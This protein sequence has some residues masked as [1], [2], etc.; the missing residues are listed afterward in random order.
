MKVI[1][2]ENLTKVFRSGFLGKPITVLK[3]IS[4]TVEK[5]EIFG[6]IGPNGAGKTTTIKIIM[7][8]LRPTSG[9]V[10]IF[11]KP[12]SDIS[13]RSKVGFLPEN[14]YF[15]DYLKARE[16]LYFY[17]KLLSMNKDYLIERIDFLLDLVGLKGIENVFLRNYS[18]GMLQRIGIAQAL[19]AD[20][21]LLILDEPMSGLDPVGRV[22]IK[23]LLLKLKKL[24]KTIFFSTHILSDAE[25]LCDRV[26]I[27]ASGEIK[28]LGRLDELLFEKSISTEIIAEG[29]KDASFIHA[30]GGNFEIKKD[31]DRWIFTTIDEKLAK[32]IVRGIISHGGRL[33]FFGKQRMKLEEVFIEAINE[34]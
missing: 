16:L 15:Y 22:E 7:D 25:M 2:I 34:S 29:L 9:R 21:E 18:K 26:A 30:L 5:G 6:F 8:I 11:G 12:P 1:V 17:G 13:W 28:K 27:I 10:S 24:G 19:L 3:G 33:I 20:P 14:P 23:D 4:L 32:E 31:N